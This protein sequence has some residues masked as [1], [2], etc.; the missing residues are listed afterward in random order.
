MCA[1]FTSAPQTQQYIPAIPNT[2][3]FIAPHYTQILMPG[4]SA[5]V[6]R[7]VSNNLLMLHNIII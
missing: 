7:F 3:Q 4:S 5:T 6:Q 1:L 2:A